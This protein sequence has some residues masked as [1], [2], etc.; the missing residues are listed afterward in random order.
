LLLI[1]A[2]IS[3]KNI[4]ETG[5]KALLLGFLLWFVLLLGTLAVVVNL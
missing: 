5:V 4:R 2:N 1:G 3:V